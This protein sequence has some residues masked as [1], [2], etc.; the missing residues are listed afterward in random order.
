MSN[1]PY[2]VGAANEEEVGVEV[3]RYSHEIL[4]HGD[5]VFAQIE[6]GQHLIIVKYRGCSVFGLSLVTSG[7]TAL[8]PRIPKEYIEN[9][10]IDCLG[11]IGGS[12]SSIQELKEILNN[13][14]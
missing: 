5:L 7:Y 8:V 1:L 6:K 9:Y 14:N 4:F 12:K 11:S 10:S 3:L 2:I 13:I